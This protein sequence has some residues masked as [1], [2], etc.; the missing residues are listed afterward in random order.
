LHAP[1]E[2]YQGRSGA[3]AAEKLD[4]WNQMAA[5]QAKIGVPPNVMSIG[6]KVVHPPPEGAVPAPFVTTDLNAYQAVAADAAYEAIASIVDIPHPVTLT[7]LPADDT[8]TARLLADGDIGI[9]PD[10]ASPSLANDIIHEYGHYIDARL[11]G[12]AVDSSGANIPDSV[13]QLLKNSPTMRAVR[14]DEYAVLKGDTQMRNYFLQGRE[15][16]ARAFDQY[17]AE[18]TGNAELLA[19]IDKTLADPLLNFQYWPHAEFQAISDEITR[20]LREHGLLVS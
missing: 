1:Y 9:A 7:H 6:E 17:I 2:A 12:A 13:Y 15:M 8:A 16:W 4:A 5:E 3:T 10:T 20:I 11:L 18:Q 14:N 19:H